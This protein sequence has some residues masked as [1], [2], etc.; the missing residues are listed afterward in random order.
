MLLIKILL[1]I[2]KIS[3]LLKN[4]MF[5]V[6]LLNKT[7]G[8]SFFLILSANTI[9]FSSISN[10]S[11]SFLFFRSIFPLYLSYLLAALVTL[12]NL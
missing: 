11:L 2:L 5:S 7:P 8:A 9:T 12:T 1:V 3:F 4:G 6:V 10:G